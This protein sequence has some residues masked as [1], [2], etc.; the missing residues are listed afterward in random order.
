MAH[1]YRAISKDGK[2]QRLYGPDN[3]LIGVFDDLDQARR[4]S[5]MQIVKKIKLPK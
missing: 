1:G 3:Q 5:D 2:K 4:F